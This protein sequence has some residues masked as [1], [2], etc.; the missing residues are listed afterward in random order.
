[1]SDQFIGEIR[2]FPF[3]FAPD[4]WE[5]CGGQILPI[6]GN[7]PLF[8]VI[9][10]TYGG[11]GVTTFALPNLQDAAPLQQGQGVNLS[12]RVQGVAGGAAEAFLVPE[13]LPAH[14]HVVQSNSGAG[15]QQSPEGNVPASAVVL[16]QGLPL[17]S[18]DPGTSPQMSDQAVGYGGNW[19]GLHNNMPPYLTLN[20]CIAVQG[21]LPQ[22]SS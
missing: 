3:N 21:D 19:S 15:D 8:S 6:S 12:E 18:A 5:L 2:V 11:D 13:Q 10:A 14:S 17:Y 1:M 20:Y 9:G 4:G 16:R 7:T 22:R